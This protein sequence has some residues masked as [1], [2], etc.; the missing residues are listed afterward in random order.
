MFS[1]VTFI[2]RI[3]TVGGVAPAQGCDQP[4][5]GDETR[6]KYQA[7]YVFFGKAK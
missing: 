2:Q 1:K 4:H 7:V 3:A 6:V 5:A